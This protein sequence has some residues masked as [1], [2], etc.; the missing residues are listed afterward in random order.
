MPSF[1]VLFEN[2]IKDMQYVTFIPVEYR[3]TG[4]EYNSIPIPIETKETRGSREGRQ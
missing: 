3:N 2:V 1:E 4:I